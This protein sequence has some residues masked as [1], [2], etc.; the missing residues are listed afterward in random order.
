MTP[1]PQPAVDFHLEGSQA[2]GRGPILLWLVRSA[3]PAAAAV[4]TVGSSVS[5]GK[6][7]QLPSPRAAVAARAIYTS[8]H[9]EGHVQGKWDPGPTCRHTGMLNPLPSAS[10]EL[11]CPRA[12]PPDDR[13]I[14]QDR[15]RVG[16]QGRHLA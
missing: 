3:S 8:A 15:R 5:S 11:Q 2:A 4:V 1:L 9:W 13:G 12:Q 6:H 7:R 16:A 10:P 14:G